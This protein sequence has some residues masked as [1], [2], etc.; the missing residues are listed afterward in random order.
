MNSSTHVRRG[1]YTHFEDSLFFRWD[2][3]KPNEFQELFI[4]PTAHVEVQDMREIPHV[5]E[6]LSWMMLLHP[7]RLTAGSPVYIRALEIP[8]I[9]WTKPSWLQV[10]SLLIFG[11][12][13]L[14]TNLG[15]QTL[16]TCMFSLHK[17]WRKHSVPMSRKKGFPKKVFCMCKS[18]IHSTSSA[19]SK[20]GANM[21]MYV[22]VAYTT[23]SAGKYLCFPFWIASP[24][25]P[26]S[27]KYSEEIH[28][29]YESQIHI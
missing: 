11:G 20:N 26:F 12:V 23:Q 16:K 25:T 14:G 28:P 22:N 18:A 7:G 21:S 10:R 3:F 27:K 6:V 17:M 8:K 15:W 2:E 4:D 29:E 9:I 1:L 19:W 13:Y 5:M 24:P